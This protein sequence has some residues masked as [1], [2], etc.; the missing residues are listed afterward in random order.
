M[1]EL[2]ELKKYAKKRKLHWEQSKKDRK[3]LNLKNIANSRAVQCHDFIFEIN[4]RLEKLKNESSVLPIFS[5]VGSTCLSLNCDK[6]MNGKWC[7]YV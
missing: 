6:T 1:A 3:E 4:E 2:E 5:I 7:G